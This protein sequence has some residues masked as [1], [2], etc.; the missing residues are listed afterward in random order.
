MG[1]LPD[2]ATGA[3]GDRDPGEHLEARVAGWRV[4]AAAAAR[5]R[6][7]WLRQAAEEGATLTGLLLDLAEAGAPVALATDLG[8]L[9]HGVVAAVGADVVVV[10]RPPR[11]AAISLASVVSV[12][13]V[14]DGRPATGDRPVGPAP[15]PTDLT[16]LLV[17]LAEARAPVTLHPLGGQAVSGVVQAVS[18]ELVAVRTHHDERTTVH[19]VMATLREVRWE[20]GP[21]SP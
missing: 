20:G 16:G 12:R 3:G 8:H 13:A 7:R 11:S 14:D 18:P 19:V 5:S 2:V 6:G 9:H 15:G 10:H 4:D 21:L 17:A 1:R